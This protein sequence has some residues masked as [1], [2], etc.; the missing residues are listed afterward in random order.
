MTRR[1]VYKDHKRPEYHLLIFHNFNYPKMLKTALRKVSRHIPFFRSRKKASIRFSQLPVM[2]PRQ[3]Q[4]EL[5]T[6]RV[7]LCL[8]AQQLFSSQL[9]TSFAPSCDQLLSSC[10]CSRL[11]RAGL[12]LRLEASGFRV[13]RH[14][15]VSR[16]FWPANNFQRKQWV[17]GC[18]ACRPRCAFFVAENSLLCSS[19][20]QLRSSAESSL[21]FLE[22][23]L[24]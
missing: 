17:R 1:M 19:C 20:G 22:Q 5:H 11:L 12:V 3:R 10:P 4:K 23:R 13:L 2:Q 16:T 15:E 21:N 8:R 18:L 9:T 24:S 7:N 14:H 6:T